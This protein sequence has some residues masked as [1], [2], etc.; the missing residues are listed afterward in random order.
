MTEERKSDIINV[1]IIVSLWVIDTILWLLNDKWFGSEHPDKGV[2]R[3]S[4]AYCTVLLIW[5]LFDNK[6]RLMYKLIRAL[7]L[8][9]VVCFNLITWV[10][11]IPWIISGYIFPG[12]L[13]GL[14]YVTY[15]V[16]WLVIAYVKRILLSGVLKREDKKAFQH[17]EERL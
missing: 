17:E 7:L 8:F 13:F 10:P 11:A 16:M 12:G 3:F 14:G 4:L 2:I 1:T 5:I 15:A 9:N 6:D